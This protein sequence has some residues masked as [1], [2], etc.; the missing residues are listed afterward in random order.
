[1]LHVCSFPD[2]TCFN[3]KVESGLKFF[4]SWDHVLSVLTT[5][6]RVAGRNPQCQAFMTKVDGFIFGIV[7][8]PYPFPPFIPRQSLGSLCEMRNMADFPHRSQLEA[9]LGAAVKAMGPRCSVERK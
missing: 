7:M 3:R 6:Y 9:A 8:T 4:S 5:F 2:I 1:M